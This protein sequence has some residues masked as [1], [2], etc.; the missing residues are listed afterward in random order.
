MSLERELE[1]RVKHLEMRLSFTRNR[2][3]YHN[4]ELCRHQE[5]EEHLISTREQVA[6]SL[7]HLVAL[8]ETSKRIDEERRLDDLRAEDE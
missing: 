7:E 3:D 8:R 6:E 5:I 4:R 1:K 2:I